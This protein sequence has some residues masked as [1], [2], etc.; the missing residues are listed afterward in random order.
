MIRVCAD[1]KYFFVILRFCAID[2]PNK[3]WFQISCAKRHN[4]CMRFVW[5]ISRSIY[6]TVRINNRHGNHAWQILSDYW[7]IGTCCKQN[8]ELRCVS[9]QPDKSFIVLQWRVSCTGIRPPFHVDRTANENTIA[10]GYLCPVIIRIRQQHSL[11]NDAMM[12]YLRIDRF[13]G[14]IDTLVCGI[15]KLIL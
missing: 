8:I 7:S 13:I 1:R 6:F 15:V 5:T 10:V 12:S 11:R 2:D 3:D 9:M 4:D 14:L